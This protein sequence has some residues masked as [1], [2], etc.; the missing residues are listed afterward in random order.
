MARLRT[1]I[2]GLDEMLM[3]GFMEGD[4]VLVAG[5]AG[6]GKT[7]FGL[8][9][10]VNGIVQ[11]GENGV[12]ITFEQLP[13]QIYRDAMTFGWDL[14]KL[15]EENK[16]RII[17]T[18]PPVLMKMIEASMFDELIRDV[19]PRRIVIDSISHLETYV[20]PSELRKEVYR[21]LM[22]FK[23]KG[24][25]SLLTW[26]VANLMNSGSPTEGVSINFLVDAI[27]LLKL[28]EIE[29]SMRRALLVLKMRGSD[30]DKTLRE[31][32]ITS[33]GIKLSSPFAGYEGIITGTPRSTRLTEDSLREWAKAFGRKG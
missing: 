19:S 16:I 10:L 11:Y 26:E 32:L 23:S 13:D 17:L 31:Y 33:Q 9:Y 14:R 12:L 2:P 20:S 6:T 22:Y 1:G 25:S 30:H 5:N 21:L 4:A 29:S 7:T 18:S 27:I 15:E 8:Q 28:V 3:G 24:L